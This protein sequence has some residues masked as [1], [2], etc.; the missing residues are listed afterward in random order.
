M[1]QLG[2]QAAKLAARYASLAK[3]GD[4]AI[5]PAFCQFNGNI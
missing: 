3:F 5:T 1:H 4:S 2:T